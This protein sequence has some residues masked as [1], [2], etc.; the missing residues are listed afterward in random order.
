M[1]RLRQMRL[2]ELQRRNYSARTITR[3]LNGVEEFAR[4]FNKPPDQLGPE[5]IRRSHAYLL[6]DRKLA[7][8]TVVQFIAALGGHLDRCSRCGHP[9][10]SYNSCRNR[11]CP[12]CHAQASDRWLAERQKGLL[13]T[14]YFHVVFTL[15]RALDGWAQVNAR[16]VYNLLF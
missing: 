7:V 11:H 15:A 1:T 14:S 5:H 3:Y 13:P 16:Q 6:N 12:K 9:A 8:G 4:Y 2:E 10:I